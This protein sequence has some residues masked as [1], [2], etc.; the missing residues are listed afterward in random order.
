[1]VDFWTTTVAVGGFVR[2]VLTAAW[3][4]YRDLLDRHKVQ[5]IASEYFIFS[6]A[7]LEVFGDAWDENEA[8]III[9]ATNIGCRPVTVTGFFLKLANTTRHAAILLDPKDPRS[10]FFDPMPKELHEGQ[11]ASTFIPARY[12]A[13]N[14]IEYAYVVDT[15]GRQWKSRRFPLCKKQ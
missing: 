5:V 12:I 10:R 4:V 1:M 3:T 13:E 11:M 7:P 14:E 9:T 6:R 8:C 2:A 15:V